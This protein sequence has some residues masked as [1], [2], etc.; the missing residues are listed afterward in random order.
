MYLNSLGERTEDQRRGGI[1]IRAESIYSSL[2]SYNTS[3]NVGSGSVERK[4]EAHLVTLNSMIPIPT[5]SS[6]LPTV[7]T[8]LLV[9]EAD[10]SDIFA[11]VPFEFR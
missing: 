11:A 4:G 7:S 9:D 6:P 5:I 2:H 8:D 3:V 10:E 1:L